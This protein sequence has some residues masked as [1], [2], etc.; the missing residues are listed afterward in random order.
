M[1]SMRLK[2]EYC[3]GQDAPIAAALF[4]SAADRKSAYWPSRQTVDEDANRL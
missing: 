2:S 1:R 3:R 4:A